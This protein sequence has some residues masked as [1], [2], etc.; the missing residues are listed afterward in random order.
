M[1]TTETF[2]IAVMT[3]QSK[4]NQYKHAQVSYYWNRVNCILVFELWWSLPKKTENSAITYHVR[5]VPNGKV[6]GI[7]S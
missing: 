3:K 4:T 7:S 2:E 5:V 6:W 1:N